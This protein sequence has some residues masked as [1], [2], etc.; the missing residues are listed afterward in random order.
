MPKDKKL[1]MEGYITGLLEVNNH[2]GC[3]ME[4]DDPREAFGFAR[5]VIGSTRRRNIVNKLAVIFLQRIITPSFVSL[6][7]FALVIPYLSAVLFVHNNDDF[8]G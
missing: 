1:Y 2:G 4:I 6:D 5:D 3:I 8:L 7:M